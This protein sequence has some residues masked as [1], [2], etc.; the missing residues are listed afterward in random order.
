MIPVAVFQV[1]WV[2]TKWM[3][4]QGIPAPGSLHPLCCQFVCGLCVS[5]LDF[6]T[7][8]KTTQTKQ[9]HMVSRSPSLSKAMYSIFQGLPS[10]QCSSCSLLG[11]FCFVLKCISPL[12]TDAFC[13]FNFSYGLVGKSK[14]SLTLISVFTVPITARNVLHNHQKSYQIYLCIEQQETFTEQGH[15]AVLAYT[16]IEEA[17]RKTKCQKKVSKY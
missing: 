8:Y 11:V 12:P 14:W 1:S 16:V 6:L 3:S 13:Q 10:I 17:S 2:H 7:T 4:S 15:W 9:I 5:W